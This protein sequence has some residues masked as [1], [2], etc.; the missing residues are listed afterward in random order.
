MSPVLRLKLPP[1]FD[2]PA[3][4]SHADGKL[5]VADTNNHAIRVL[6]L[7]AGTVATIAGT[8]NMGRSVIPAGIEALA[9]NLRSPWDV[10]LGGDTTLY[11]A[12]AGTHQI[13]AMDLMAN[14]LSPAV[15][16]G[17]EAMLNDSLLNSELAQPSGLY[18]VGD[19]VY[20]ADS[21]SSTIRVD[22]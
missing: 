4:L 7:N 13:W 9:V 14:T 16:N 21:E 8:G 20:F 19:Q 12:M 3:G 11:I 22:K 18:V 5:Y 10:A 2:E 1:T 17:R 15:G 6:D